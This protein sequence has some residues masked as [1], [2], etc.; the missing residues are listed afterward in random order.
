MFSEN[1]FEG[2]SVAAFNRELGVSHNLIH[3]RFGSKEALWYVTGDWA[4]GQIADQ[5]V[6]VDGLAAPDPVE[7]MRVM[8]HR[9]LEVH[10]RHPHMS[11]LVTMEAATANPRLT[12]S[13][14]AHVVPLP[15]AL[16]AP[17]KTLVDR[18]VLTEVPALRDRPKERPRRSA[19]CPSPRCSTPVDPLGPDAVREHACLVSDMIAAGL[20]ARGAWPI[21]GDE[22]C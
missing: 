19:W 7:A 8:V 20:R 21:P 6:D 13:Y 14:E 9:L 17:V 12:H 22:I 18:G 15:L 2:T 16:L 5:L 1:G 10:S 3:Q 11:R 4:F